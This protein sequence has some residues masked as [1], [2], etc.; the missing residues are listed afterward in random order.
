MRARVPVGPAWG[1][2]RP[3]GG[4][5][6]GTPWPPADSRS[7]AD[8]ASIRKFERARASVGR[9]Q[10]CDARRSLCQRGSRAVHI[11]PAQDAP[12]STSGNDVQRARRLANYQALAGAVGLRP[13]LVVDVENEARIRN[14]TGFSRSR[15]SVGYAS[16]SEVVDVVA[17]LVAAALGIVCFTQVIRS[18]R[19]GVLKGR[20]APIHRARQRI[21][22]FVGIW[23]LALSGLI[24][25]AVA[26]I[27]GFR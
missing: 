26:F 16:R 14:G 2:H 1:R 12:L 5:Q 3:V 4:L 7:H 25:F 24:L 9:H 15:R 11:D 8:P 21:G 6:R 13:L 20:V 17:S 19:S 27:F 22:F 23:A 10:R 18:L